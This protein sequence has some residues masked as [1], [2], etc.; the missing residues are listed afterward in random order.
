MGQK[1]KK[2]KHVVMADMRVLA[3]LVLR[4]RI[5]SLNDNLCTQNVL[6]REYFDTLSDSIKDLTT[7]ENR[8]IKPGLKMKIGFLLKKMIKIAKGYFI[9]ADKM[10][11]SVEIDRFSAVLDLNWDYIFY[12]AQVMCEQRRN[13]LRK[14]QAMP[15]AEDMS[16]FRVFILHEM[17]KLS[18]DEF[19]KWDHHDFV[20]MRN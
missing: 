16:R 15:S 18:D 17:Q 9:Q 19:K 2:E 12:T 5:L 7:G 14:P 20:K 3:N 13:S 8:Q 6:E 11:E 4:M 10:E 1:H